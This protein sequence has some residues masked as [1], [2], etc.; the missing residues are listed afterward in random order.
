MLKTQFIENFSVGDEVASVFLI[1]SASQ[2]Q[3]KNG[4]F[5]KLELRDATGNLEA[6]IW[7]PMSQAYPVVAAGDMVEVVGRI[8]MYREKLEIA[9][10]R[11]RF[12]DEEERLSLDTAL[13]LPSTE[14]PPVEILAELT[15][16][17]KAVFTHGPWKKLILGVLADP[18]VRQ[19]LLV[20]PAA[21]A[22]HHAYAG[23]L[24]EHTLSVAKLCMTLADLYPY[25]DRQT[26]LAGA[27]F[28][29]IGKVW[30][31][32]QGLAADYTDSGR[33][34][35]H[36]QL[37]LDYLEPR[38]RK[39]GLEAGLATHLKHLVISHHGKHEFGSAKL[40]ATL[41]AMALHYADDL[42]AKLN[43]IHAALDGIPEGENGWS[44][45]VFGLERSLFKAQATP[46]P[47][48]EVVEADVCKTAHPKSVVR[49][50]ANKD[51]HLLE[52]DAAPGQLSLLED[53]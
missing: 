24:V 38:I 44:G 52:D 33:L 45:R 9:V 11:L 3:A 37:L 13:F 43:Q 25:L 49:T 18:E 14:R 7:S 15:A 40:P 16:L 26:L 34:L 41:E 10:G 39:S 50:N 30:E 17:C 53:M 20:T 4:P 12:L 36:I 21:K 42:D 6:K 5:W 23:G 2:G 8:S 31:L 51:A 28:H 19:R 48:K 29:D 47:D 27:V 35:G 46:L 22:M 32:T 1:G